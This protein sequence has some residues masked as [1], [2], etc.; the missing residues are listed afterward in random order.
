LKNL[1]FASV[2]RRRLC[3]EGILPKE[4]GNQSHRPTGSVC[5]SAQFEVVLACRLARA[6]FF[7]V[8]KLQ[9]NWIP[10]FFEGSNAKEAALNLK[11]IY[12]IKEQIPSKAV[13]KVDTLEFVK[14]V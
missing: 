11:G 10:S 13:D 9:R 8:N 6:G 2:V 14:F 4:K 5:Y 1:S 12:G 7:H 3:K